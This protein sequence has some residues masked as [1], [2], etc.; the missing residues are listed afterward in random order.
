M[1]KHRGSS[2]QLSYSNVKKQIE[3]SGYKLLSKEYKNHGSMI[4]ICCPKGHSYYVKYNNFQQGQRCPICWNINN[5][6]RS[7]KDCLNVV[8]QFTNE[9]VIENDRTQLVNPKTGKYLEL[10]VWIP[11]LKKAIEFNGEYWHKNNYKD[12]VKIEQCK[13]RDIDLIIIWYNDWMDDKQKVIENITKFLG[14]AQ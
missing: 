2:Q 8:K 5:Y 7:E 13:K 11:S 12:N 10:D 3:K 14:E 4:N 1:N 6:S 9:N